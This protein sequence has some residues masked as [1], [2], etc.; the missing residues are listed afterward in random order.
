MTFLRRLA[1]A[2]IAG[3]IVFGTLYVGT[4][5]EVPWIVGILILVVAYPAGIEYLQLMKRLDVPLA[6]PE[7]LIWI[8]VLMFAYVIFD[9]RYGDAVLLLAIAYQV[10]R[11]LRSVPHRRGFLQTIAGV[12]GLLY[13]PWLLHFFYFIYISGPADRPHVGA[14]HAL[15]ILLMVWGY[16]SGAYFIG[17]LLG[18]HQA[19]PRVSP[20]KTWEGI[21]GGFLLTVV[22]A[23]I[24]ASFSPVW[25]QFAFW[26]GFPHILASS[27]LVGLAVQLGDVFESKLK[28]AAQVKDSGSFLPGHGGA[29]D[30]IDGLLFALPVF[31]F[32]YNYVLGFL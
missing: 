17:S 21:I 1:S 7:F 25:R 26:E 6:A 32:Y 27:F 24:G 28:R 4:R 14:T 13:I 23:S 30:R 5:Y 29:L 2:I 8:P 18:R 19:F 22:G 31:F 3:G 15:V 20:K 9:G 11:Y 16:D 10:L 12:F